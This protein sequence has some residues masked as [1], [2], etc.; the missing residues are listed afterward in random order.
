MGHSLGGALAS[1]CSS[2]MLKIGLATPDHLRLVTF[3]QPRTGDKDWA[4]WHDATV[5]RPLPH[6]HNPLLQF[7][8]SYR[9]VHHKD[10]V[11]HIPPRGGPDEVWHHRFEIWYNNAMAVGDPYQI[12]AEDDGLYC[13]NTQVEHNN[14]TLSK[15]ISRLI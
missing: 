6:C 15:D 10:I 5:I 13:S 12:C 1:V 2:Y 11:P 4:Q 8:Y 9:I 14:W 3:G 7:L